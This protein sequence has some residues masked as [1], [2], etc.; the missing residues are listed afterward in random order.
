MR[1]RIGIAVL[2][3]VLSAALVP[4]SIAR[5]KVPRQF[6][7]VFYGQSDV[8]STDLN[9]FHQGRVG[10][11][12][13]VLSWPQVQPTEGGGYN[14]S[15]AD[16]II[17]SLASKGVKVLPTLYGSP[18]FAASSPNRPPLGSKSARKAWK[19]FLRAAVKRYGP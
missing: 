14:W 17:G 19:Q 7:G 3:A 11:A 15:S 1:R 8:T 12:R 18:G 5:A 10:T 2:L 16:H 6:W 13:W 9:R 4:G